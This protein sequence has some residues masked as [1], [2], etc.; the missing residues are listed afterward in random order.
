MR[1]GKGKGKGEKRKG[2]GATESTG[3]FYHSLDLLC[4]YFNVS[5]SN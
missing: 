4:M 2:K 5:K 1:R 3:S